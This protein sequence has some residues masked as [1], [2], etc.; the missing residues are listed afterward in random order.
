VK[1]SPRV[2]WSSLRSVR[3]W[4]FD[5]VPVHALLICRVGLGAV[6]FLAYLSRWPLVDLIYGPEGYAGYGYLQRFPENAA[7]GW[8]LVQHFSYLQHWSSGTAIWLLYLVLLISSLCFA[9]GVWPKVT[10]TMALALHALFV[11]RN[12]AA[13]WGWATMIKP[14]LLYTILASSSR[15]WSVVSWL[16]NRA[17][18]ARAP[19]EWT[20]PAWPLRLLQVHI[21]CVFLV[22]WGRLDEDSWLTGQMLSVALVSRDWARFDIDWFP[23]LAYM[24][25][26]GLTALFLEVGAPI[27]LWIKPIGKYWALALMGMFFTLVV[28]TSIGWWDFVMM[29][30]LTAF[31]PKQW[32]E[33]VIGPGTPTD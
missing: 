25:W 14:F 20:C 15:Q 33:R 10:G 21:A 27:A 2:L 19:A 26:A 7:V 30:A 23:Y 4:L 31:L 22:V 24:E 17:G 8:S 1:P 11:A 29:V 32:L 6:L 5:P 16:R 9:L 28:T 18:P 12:P 13:T 3:G